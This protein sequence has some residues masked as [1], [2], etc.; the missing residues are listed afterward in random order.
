MPRVGLNPQ[1]VVR[2]AALLA[3]E[4][5]YQQLTLA[6]LA[7]RLGVALPSL[8]KHIKGAEALAQKLAALATAELAEEM[9]TA[10]AGRSREEALRAVATAYR[11]YARRHPGRYPMAQRVPDPADP[12]HVAAGERAVGVVYAIL[13]GYG[14]EGDSAVDGVRMFRAAVHGFVA[15][16]AEGDFGLPREV[17]R[18]F[19]Q[20]ITALDVAFSAWPG[21]A[22]LD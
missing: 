10:A 22:D 16:E 21:G 6:A 14:I 12:A 13:R 19:E 1:I 15:L 4:V 3:D 11:S 2:E 17:D 20:M 9:T 5:G 18:S 7:G 8:Y